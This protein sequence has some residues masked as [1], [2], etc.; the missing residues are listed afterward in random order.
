VVTTSCLSESADSYARPFAATAPW[1]VPVCGL[2]QDSRSA[3]WVNRFYYYAN[4]N[5]FMGGDPTKATNSTNHTV[6][7]GLDADPAN[8]FS[9]AVYDAADA[10]TTTRVFQRSGWGGS[11]N[12]GNG[13]TMPWNPAW[14]ASTGSDALLVVVDHTT[15][16]EWSL[17]GLAQS[18]YGLPVNDTQCWGWIPYGYVRGTDLCVGSANM[19][20]TANQTT[21]VNTNTYGGNNPAGRGSG[22]D[23]YAL[24]ATPQEAA[25]G[26]I[27]HALAMPVF[28]TMNGGTGQVCTEAQMSTTAFGSTCGQAVAPAGQFENKSVTTHGCGNPTPAAL[29]S[30]TAYRQTTLPEGTRFA[31]HMS[32][33]DIENWLNSRGYTGQKR[34]TAKAFAVALVNYGWFITDTS[35]YGAPFQVSGGSNPDTAAGWRALGITGDGTDLLTGLIT[36]DRIWTVAPPTNHCTNGTSSKAACPADTITYP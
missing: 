23:E 11:M 6:M 12:F 16:H 3:D 31:L 36:K 5:Q 21:A 17:W 8:D 34:I 25:T 27:R 10:T 19:S 4:Y 14:R 15:G 33:Q 28:D 32:D 2:A 30:D 1:N 7:F 26:Q 13:G 20:K 18:T 29:L 22:L 9:V 24:T 35:C